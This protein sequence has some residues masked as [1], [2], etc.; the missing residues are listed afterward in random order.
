MQAEQLGSVFIA[1][2]WL[3][4]SWIIFWDWKNVQNKMETNLSLETK[5]GQG[6]KM[7]KTKRYRQTLGTDSQKYLDLLLSN[8]LKEQLYIMH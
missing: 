2:N 6:E 8:S 5:L 3:Q 7:V 4:I 1:K